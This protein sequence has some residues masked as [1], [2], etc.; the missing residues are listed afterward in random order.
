M[1]NKPKTPARTFRL[2][3]ETMSK[4]AELTADG[5]T[6]TDSVRGAIDAMYAFNEAVNAGIPTGVPLEALV[7][8]DEAAWLNVR[9]EDGEAQRRLVKALSAAEPYMTEAARKDERQRTLR[10]VIVRLEGM[11]VDRRAVDHLKSL[12][13]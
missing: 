7:A 13:D 2:S 9:M 6:L 3:D 8:A 4:V 11:Q 12:L 5:R 1:P 10:D